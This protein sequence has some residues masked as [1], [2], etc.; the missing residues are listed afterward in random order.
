MRLIPEADGSVT[1]ALSPIIYYDGILTSER[2]WD[3]PMGLLAC[4]TLLR[5][6]QQRAVRP[7]NDVSSSRTYISAK[8]PVLS[9]KG[10]RTPHS[11]PSGSMPAFSQHSLYCGRT[12]HTKN[13]AR[14]HCLHHPL[15]S[16]QTPYGSY[17]SQR[18]TT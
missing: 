10:T 17:V 4:L 6:S 12:R 7:Y 18:P 11:S 15:R 9:A 3:H 14:C 8:N 16:Q 13:G 1:I 2:P 5:P